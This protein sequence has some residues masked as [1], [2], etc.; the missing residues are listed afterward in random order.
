M[1]K[2]SRGKAE[3]NMDIGAKSV[4]GK[5]KGSRFDILNEEV[6][7]MLAEDA[8]VNRSRRMV[9][10]APKDNN[11]LL[12]VTNQKNKQAEKV[13]KPT[14][15]NGLLK[16]KK[17]DKG[18]SSNNN[19]NL[20]PGKASGASSSKANSGNKGKR[21]SQKSTVQVNDSKVIDSGSASP[22]P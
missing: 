4:I 17:G 14:V 22:I 19:Q 13:I 9:S 18:N 12:D 15:Q 10:K 21:Q 20:L 5:G 7:V 3:K 1:G 6:E 11:V 8:S 16:S 2:E